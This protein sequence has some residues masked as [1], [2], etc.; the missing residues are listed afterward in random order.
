MNKLSFP[1][2]CTSL[3]SPLNYHSLTRPSLRCSVD[4]VKCKSPFHH[5]KIL[6]YFSRI[7]SRI[8]IFLLKK[9]KP[10]FVFPT[11]LGEKKESK[12]VSRVLMDSMP[13]S[14][15]SPSEIVLCP[16][17]CVNSLKIIQFKRISGKLSLKI[18]MY[19]IFC[20]EKRS[21]NDSKGHSEKFS[22]K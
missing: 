19:C 9:K 8:P 20:L 17:R 6:N 1:K 11:F 3:F 13:H 15:P 7:N 5:T 16:K 12:D 2:P 22:Q 18:P 4:T 14:H 21:T 10:T